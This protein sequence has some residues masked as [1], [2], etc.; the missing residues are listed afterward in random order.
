MQES[1]MALKEFITYFNQ[2]CQNVSYYERSERQTEVVTSLN[3]D[4]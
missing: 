4:V 1:I 3:E 2:K